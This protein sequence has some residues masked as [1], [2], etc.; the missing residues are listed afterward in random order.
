MRESVPQLQQAGLTV[1]VLADMLA[2]M[3]APAGRPMGEMLH[4]DALAATAAGL[5]ELDAS[6]L[7]PVLDGTI[8]PAFDPAAPIPV[9]VL[10]LTA[11]PSSPDA[12]TR[13][14]DVAQLATVSPHAE[15]QVM[16][17]ASH[18]I[19]DELAHRELFREIVTTFV[20]RISSGR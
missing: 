15:I 3:P 1:D 11:D 9:P 18:L 6:V 12:V 20:D 8:T 10:L 5:L 17:G 4:R 14:A 19:H 7:D 2:Q 16:N 13:P